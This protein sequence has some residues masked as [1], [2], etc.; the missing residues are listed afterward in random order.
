MS[1]GYKRLTLKGSKENIN[2]AIAEIRNEA[3]AGD[4]Y[5]VKPNKIV[6][7]RKVLTPAEYDTEGNEITPATYS[8]DYFATII[9]RDEQQ[10]N[11]AIAIAEKKGAT[12]V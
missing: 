9:V 11:A 8:E 3:V 6:P 1:D 5:F 4:D 12:V 2:T 7:A 10:M